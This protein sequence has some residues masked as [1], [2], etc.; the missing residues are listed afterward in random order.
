MWDK[1]YYSFILQTRKLRHRE[2]EKLCQNYT[3]SKWLLTL[4]FVLASQLDFSEKSELFADADFLS[5]LRPN[6]SLF[7]NANFLSVKCQQ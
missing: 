6:T 3:A 1:Y 5:S 2:A 7:S 4:A